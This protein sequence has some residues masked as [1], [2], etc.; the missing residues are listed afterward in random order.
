MIKAKKHSKKIIDFV[1][2]LSKIEIRVK[3]R[4]INSIMSFAGQNLVNKK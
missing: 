3:S 4:V 1:A 2:K